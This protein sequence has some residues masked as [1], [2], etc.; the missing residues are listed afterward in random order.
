MHV[1]VTSLNICFPFPVLVTSD[2]ASFIYT[3]FK[4]GLSHD[5]YYRKREGERKREREKKRGERETEKDEDAPSSIAT[6]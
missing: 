2:F 1:K 4:S 3:T 5:V 6:P